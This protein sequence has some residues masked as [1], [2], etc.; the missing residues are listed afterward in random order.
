MAFFFEMVKEDCF[1]YYC[2]VMCLNFGSP[3][4]INFSFLTNEK[5]TVFGVPILKLFEIAV[6]V[7]FCNLAY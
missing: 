4:I 1:S 6:I 2:I 5:I 3:Q 7:K